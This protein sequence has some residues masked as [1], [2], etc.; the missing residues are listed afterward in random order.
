MVAWPLLFSCAMFALV[1]RVLDGK[2]AVVPVEKVRDFRPLNIHDFNLDIL[3]DVFWSGDDRT[4][5]GFYE[6]RI[7]RVAGKQVSVF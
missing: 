5:G 2:A 7:L 1:R 3:Y 4:K 6:A